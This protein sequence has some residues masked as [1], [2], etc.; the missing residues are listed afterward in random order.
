AKGIVD[1]DTLASI[2]LIQE[3]ENKRV[4]MGHLAFVGSHK[5]NGVSALHTELM[6]RTVFH[7]LNHAKPGRIVNL[8]NGITFRRWLL[9]AN[10][11][12][13]VLL[14]RF[15]GERL[16]DDPEELTQLEKLAEDPGFAQHFAAVK[17][18]NKDALAR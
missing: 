12:L 1:P 11:E 14:T 16:L 8:T 15:L 2:S 18:S 10:P 7:D 9:E 17:R 6:G 3:G 5:I 13:T 4:R